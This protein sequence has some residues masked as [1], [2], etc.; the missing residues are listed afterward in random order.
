M[1]VTE[2][3][4]LNKSALGDRH[5]FSVLYTTQ[6]SGLTKY[7]NLFNPSPEDNEEIIQDVFLRIWEKKEKLAG[8]ESFRAY[9]FRASKNQLLDKL[10]RLQLEKKVLLLMAPDTEDSG[11][12]IDDE[13]CYEEYQSVAG[14]AIERLTDKRSCIF[15]LRTTEGLS[16]DEIADKLKISKSVVKK[17][18][19]AASS[20]VM[21]YLRDRGEMTI[22]LVISLILF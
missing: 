10:R 6:L 3:E 21:E 19:Y 4:L 22:S 8:I 9:V 15:E 2:K 5:A 14:R 1:E 17:Q 16:L 11:V 12:R 20:S 7:L 18:Y 13:L